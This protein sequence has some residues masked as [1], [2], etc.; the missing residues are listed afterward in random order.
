MILRWYSDLNH[1]RL[2]WNMM[3]IWFLSNGWYSL[4]NCHNPFGKAFQPTP[5]Y[6][7]I[8]VE[9][10]KS[11]H[12]S[13]LSG[14]T[15]IIWNAPRTKRL[16]NGMPDKSHFLHEHI[17]RSENSTLKSI[18][19]ISNL[20]CR[21]TIIIFCRRCNFGLSQIICSAASQTIQTKKSPPLPW[22]IIRG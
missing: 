5:P 13:S 14:Q 6:G 12:G 7:K 20:N 2:W 11:L 22:I 8:P 9:H 15:I 3:Q 17:L 4:K 16:T 18:S 19:I 21:I 1:G 10:L